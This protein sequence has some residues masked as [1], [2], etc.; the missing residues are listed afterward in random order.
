MINL[1]EQKLIQ[2]RL[3]QLNKLFKIIKN[4]RN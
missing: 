4:L 3:M 2:T 1:K